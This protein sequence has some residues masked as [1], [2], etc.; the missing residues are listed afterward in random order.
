MD[1]GELV[2]DEHR[3][4]GR[5]RSASRVRSE[6]EPGFVL[7]GFPARPH[8][9]RASSTA[10]WREHPLD[11]VVNLDVPTDMAIERAARRAG[12][13]HPESITRRL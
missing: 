8:Q 2:P 1:R 9:A 13:R 6:V 11:V 3:G 7:D 12:G 10:S 5:R 4:R